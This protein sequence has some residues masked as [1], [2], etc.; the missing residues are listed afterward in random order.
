M[1]E[2][3]KL[4]VIGGG[5]SGFFCAVNAARLNANLQV[6]ILEKTSKVLSKVRISGGGRCNVTHRSE[7]VGDLLPAYPRGKNFVRKTLHQ[8]PP[9]KTISWFAERGVELKVEPDG[10]MFPVS[11]QS[12]TIIDCLLTEAKK[13]NVELR[14]R[15][16]VK[17]IETDKNVFRIAIQDEQRGNEIL[18][19]DFV[20]VAAGGHP[21]L[22][23]F[24]FLEKTGHSI[25]TPV[26]SLF[27]FNIAEKTLHELMGISAPDAIVKIPELKLQEQGPLLITHWGL[28][29]PAVL[30]LSARA[31]R[32]LDARAHHFD[33]TVNWCATYHE[34]AALEILKQ[35]RQDARHEVNGRNP[36]SMTSRLWTYLIIKAGFS[37]TTKWTDVN[38]ALLIRLSKILTADIFNVQ[39]KTTF[40][41]EF[42]TAG[43]VSIK[44]VNPLTMES[45]ICKGLFFAGEV[46]DVDG[47]T[48]GYN[49]QHA[50]SSGWIAANSITSVH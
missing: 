36:F 4:I 28:S 41:E 16:E 39:G 33:I 37:P 17:T 30:R 15:C 43:G 29:G 14:T 12:E 42:V 25:I 24:N 6:L 11:D 35:Y 38:N 44:E 45:L 2:T 8:F 50:W 10:R 49:F 34:S 7:E 40:K 23:G 48:G 46:V 26:P 3:K 31:A 1:M 27:T 9:S 22:T 20:C 21:K 47:I 5:A 19:T 13:F 18:E 32:E